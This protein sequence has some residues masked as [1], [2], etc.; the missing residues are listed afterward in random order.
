MKVENRGAPAS[1]PFRYLPLRGQNSSFKWRLD[2]NADR[3]AGANV[4]K[5]P[6]CLYPRFKPN[7]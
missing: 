5:A 2:R 1:K 3:L 4:P 7:H 6:C